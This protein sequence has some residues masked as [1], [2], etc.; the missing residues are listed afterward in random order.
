MFDD[1]DD[2]LSDD[3]LFEGLELDSKLFDFK[4]I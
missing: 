3:S 4:K 1:L 2:I